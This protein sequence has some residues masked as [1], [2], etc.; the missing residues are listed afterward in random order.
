MTSAWPPTKDWFC[1]PA[2]QYQLR[3][4]AVEMVETREVT[5]ES[6]AEGLLALLQY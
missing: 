1:V 4:V 5:V 6:V 3:E 2:G